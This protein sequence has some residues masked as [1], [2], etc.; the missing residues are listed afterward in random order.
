LANANSRR[1]VQ[2]H[3]STPQGAIDSYRI[4]DIA[5]DQFGFAIEVSGRPSR[6][7]VHLGVQIVE[8][9]DFVSRRQENVRDV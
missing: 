4:G 9:P 8:Q 7:P 2:H 3:I 6:G 5:D 1:K